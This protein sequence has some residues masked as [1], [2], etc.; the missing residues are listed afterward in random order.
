MP[1]HIGL[2]SVGVHWHTVV[3]GMC[4][5]IVTYEIFTSRYIKM[6][7]SHLSLHSTQCAQTNECLP[8][9][10]MTTIIEFMHACS[11]IQGRILF[12]M[13]NQRCGY[14]MMAPTIGGAAWSTV[15][16]NNIIPVYQDVSWCKRWSKNALIL[17][18]A[19]LVYYCWTFMICQTN[20]T[21]D[22]SLAITQTYVLPAA[23]NVLHHWKYCTV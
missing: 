20:N 15:Y 4:T 8:L 23:L 22:G 11:F 21:C 1:Q 19:S 10:I 3:H 9:V 18:C 16:L 7:I 17:C 14:Y 2:H 13:L 12:L 5:Y 6:T